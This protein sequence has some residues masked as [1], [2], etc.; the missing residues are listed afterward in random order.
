MFDMDDKEREMRRKEVWADDAEP[1]TSRAV[2]AKNVIGTTT[3]SNLPKLCLAVL[4]Q[5]IKKDALTAILPAI[6]ANRR[7]KVSIYTIVSGMYTARARLPPA[8]VVIECKP[9]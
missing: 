2:T 7:G 1:Q 3:S 8:G 6:S 5:K 9:L 4:Q